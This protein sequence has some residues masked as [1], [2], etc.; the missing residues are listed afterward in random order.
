MNNDEVIQAEV[1]AIPTVIDEIVEKP[2]KVKV[3]KPRK[4]MS[5][6][7]KAKLVASLVKAR[8]QSAL[9]RGLK[10]QAKKIIKEKEDAE[11][12]E[13][14]RKSLLAKDKEDPRDIQIK[15]LKARLDGLTLQDVVKKPKKKAL[16]KVIDNESEEDLMFEIEIEKEK[17]KPISKAS[18][19]PMEEINKQS[20]ISK[21]SKD[22]EE[23]KTPEPI[24]LFQSLRGSKFKKGL[25]R[26]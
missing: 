1:P 25:K 19:E 15:E 10:S 17:P 2:P 13:I 22:E 14:I 3:K 26:Y 5:E 8:E 24:K 12:N 6:E 4:P 18:K 20:S 9:K 21:A 23:E 7:H 16:P 11:T